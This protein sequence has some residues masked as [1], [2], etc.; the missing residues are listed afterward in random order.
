MENKVKKKLATVLLT[1][2]F[3]PI[4]SKYIIT[5]VKYIS[6]VI[7]DI[8]YILFPVFL[9]ATIITLLINVFYKNQKIQTVFTFCLIGTIIG[10]MYT[11]FYNEAF[12]LEDVFLSLSF[13]Y[14]LTLS[15][16]YIYL[17]SLVILFYQK[18]KFRLNILIFLILLLIL[19]IDFIKMAG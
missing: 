2:L 6:F 12:I 4:I 13:W 16:P 3:L 5:L 10:L 11:R 8:M 15:L 14:L 7:P 19:L 9:L 1:L 18:Q 17:V